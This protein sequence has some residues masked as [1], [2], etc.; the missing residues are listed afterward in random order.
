MDQYNTSSGLKEKLAEPV[1]FQVSKP[2]EHYHTTNTSLSAHMD[3]QW[4]SVERPKGV[5]HPP[6]ITQSSPKEAKNI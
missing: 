3:G 1:R 2:I 6:G 4:F 5:P